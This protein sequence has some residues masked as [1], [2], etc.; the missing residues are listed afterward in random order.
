MAPRA[1]AQTFEQ[2]V[3]GAAHICALDA[4]GQLECTSASIAQRLL[5][6]A[7]LPPLSDIVAGQQHTCGVVLDGQVQCFDG[8]FFGESEPPVFDSP[9]IGIT[10][11]FNHN[12]AIDSD[13]QV[14]CWGLNS[15]GQLD[16]PDTVDGFVKVDASRNASCGITTN[17]DIQ[18]WSTDSFYQ[19]GTII[20]G[21]FVDLDG[22]ANLACAL[23]V[24]GD[25]DCFATRP[26]RSRT[27]PN[28]GPY[29]DLTLTNSAICELRADQLLDRSFPN[30][31][32]VSFDP[33]PDQYPVDVAFSS[34]ER[35]AF[36]AGGVPIC[37][38]RADNGT[39]SCFGGTTLFKSALAAPPGTETVTDTIN[40]SNIR[41]SLTARIYGRNQIELFYSRLP[42]VF[43]PV[44][45][46]IFR[47]DALLT[48]TQNGFSFYDDDPTITAEVSQYRIRIVDG[49]G[50]VSEFSNTIVVDRVAQ[51]VS[52]L[53][54]TN[55]I[56]NPNLV[57]DVSIQNTDLVTFSRLV[58]NDDAYIL[59]W[60]LDNP[61]NAAVAGFEIRLNDEV[62]GF[63][64]NTT[65]IGNGARADRCTIFNVVAIA[66]D[67]AILNFGSAAF[68]RSALTC[69]R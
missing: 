50:N 28:N 4:S 63:T 13:N 54:N 62:V 26:G 56:E 59:T 36:Q 14:Q 39:I 65:F 49:Q 16:V 27:P 17:G 57:S 42:S 24:D 7:D 11:G 32:S 1:V 64:S 60:S 18:C 51:T 47:D 61:S 5:P 3:V 58:Q 8:N 6:P 30:A 2:V 66:N 38:V 48:T 40:A 68:G 21:P 22:D 20:R 35:S 45:V 55:N 9:V 41:L 23:T 53:D 33:A 46:E 31:A 52:P 15:N 25:I 69:P 44:S 37:G 34:I 10:A 19:P 29:T 12:C 43:P 67:G